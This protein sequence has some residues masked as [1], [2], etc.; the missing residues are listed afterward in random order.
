MTRESDGTYFTRRAQQSRTARNRAGDRTAR[1]A[2]DQLAEAYERR[3]LFGAGD[4]ESAVEESGTAP[5]E[6]PQAPT[7]GSRS[8]T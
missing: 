1:L 4:G 6:N 8:T 3:A 2:H 7:A 5:P